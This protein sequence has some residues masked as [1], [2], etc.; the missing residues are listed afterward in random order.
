[1]NTS[2]V[3]YDSFFDA[4]EGLPAEIYAECINALCSYALRGEVPENMGPAAKIYFRLV[5]PVIDTNNKRRENGSK[6]G[7]PRKNLEEGR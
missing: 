7:R 4:L 3:F 2:F 6:G 5:K 1:M